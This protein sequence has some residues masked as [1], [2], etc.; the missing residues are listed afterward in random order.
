MNLKFFGFGE[1]N[2]ELVLLKKIK[3]NSKLLNSPEKLD[4]FPGLNLERLKN[5]QE[6]DTSIMLGKRLASGLGNLGEEE[7]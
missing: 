2:R 1:D 6:L 3:D 7:S 5:S 4:F